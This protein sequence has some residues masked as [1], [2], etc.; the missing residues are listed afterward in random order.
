MPDSMRAAVCLSASQSVHVCLPVYRSIWTSVYISVLLSLDSF[1]SLSLDP[2][3]YLYSCHSV[4]VSVC[5]LNHLCICVCV[6]PF[7]WVFV[8]LLICLFICVP[9]C[10]S[11]HSC[12]YAVAVCLSVPILVR[13]SV[14]LY[15]LV[16]KR[17]LADGIGIESEHRDACQYFSISRTQSKNF[18]RN[19]AMFRS[20]MACSI[21]ASKAVWTRVAINAD[22]NG[23]YELW[24]YQFRSSAKV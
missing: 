18:V 12:V 22:S 10:F 17:L 6:S 16:R 24:F 4:S 19:S 20:F 3:A 1:V 23:N 21:D 11:N 13:V 5:L 9:A 2:C 15:V 8:Y 14:C 7:I